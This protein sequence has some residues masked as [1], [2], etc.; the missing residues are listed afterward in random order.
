MLF[1]Y[2][3]NKRFR[4]VVTDLGMLTQIAISHNDTSCYSVSIS[5]CVF[6]S[7]GYNV[8]CHLPYDTHRGRYP[9]Q[10]IMMQGCNWQKKH[11]ICRNG[12]TLSFTHVR[13][14]KS[15]LPSTEML[16]TC[17]GMNFPLACKAFLAASLSPPQQGTSIRTMV[18]LWMSLF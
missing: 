2:I 8:S 4:A 6:R 12:K 1:R 7:F 3:K 17:Q 14:S 13:H 10:R 9:S 15:I 18:M 16:M 5:I 11:Y